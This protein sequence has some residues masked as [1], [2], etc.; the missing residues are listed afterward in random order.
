MLKSR[1]YICI[2]IYTHTWYPRT[3]KIR[4]FPP[5]V[6]NALGRRWS[7]FCEGPKIK[8]HSR[9]PSIITRDPEY[10]APQN[11]VWKA[12]SISPDIQICI[13]AFRFWHI[14]CRQPDILEVFLCSASPI[15][16]FK[17]IG[18]MHDLTGTATSVSSQ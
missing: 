11:T 7:R 8:S 3:S 12:F 13:S 1:S 2:Y 6:L 14:K 16:I 5:T 15:F 9:G 10:V 17:T 18:A 4:A